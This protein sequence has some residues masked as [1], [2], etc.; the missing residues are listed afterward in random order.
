MPTDVITEP[1][2]PSSTPPGKIVEVRELPPRAGA[3]ALR[4]ALKGFREKVEKGEI[5]IK[6]VAEDDDRPTLLEQHNKDEDAAGAEPPIPETDGTAEKTPVA[7]TETVPVAPAKPDA[8]A[9]PEKKEPE[10]ITV[11]I[12]EGKDAIEIE[13]PTQAVADRIKELQNNGLRK[14]EWK[15]RLAKVEQRE[16]DQR[17]VQS[18]IEAS[19][20]MF[21][22]QYAPPDKRL[23]M[24]RALLA[25]HLAD[26][27]PD[28]VKWADPTKGEAE[29]RAFLAEQKNKAMQAQQQWASQQQAQRQAMQIFRSVQSLIP[30]DAPEERQQRFLR[31][32]DMELTDAVKRGVAISTTNVHDILKAVVS[33]FG[34]DKPAALGNGSAGSSVQAGSAT[35]AKRQRSEADRQTAIAK[36]RATGRRIAPQGAGGIPAQPPQL[37]KPTNPRNAIA[38]RIAYLRQNP[39][40]LRTT[41]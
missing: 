6:D 25:E 17:A 3:N 38:E 15:D 5:T 13:A 39:G 40:L 23:D 14:A 41:E 29:R 12:G 18:M 33:D 27:V 36:A 26:L 31:I 30:E 21:V 11:T 28:V 2:Q 16:A 4:D 9:E 24:A 34:F 35:P 7:A 19:P 10:L 1:V 37:P 22:L 8:K 32:A 20:D